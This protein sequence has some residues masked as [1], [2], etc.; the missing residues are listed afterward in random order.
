MDE[1]VT[2]DGSCSMPRKGENNRP[3]NSSSP[4]N[5]SKNSTDEIV[6]AVESVTV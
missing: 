1:N 4:S 5:K 3:S 6:K 2:F